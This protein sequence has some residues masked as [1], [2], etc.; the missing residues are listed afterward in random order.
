MS[1][2]ID[3]PTTA[4]PAKVKKR[5]VLLVANGDLRLAANQVC[6][7]AQAEMERGLTAAVAEAGYE[8]VRAHPYLENQK[9][10]FISSQQEGMRVFSQIDRDAR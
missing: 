6:W 4:E 8:L 3:L 5:Q 1:A 9:H 10:G 2:A 7:A